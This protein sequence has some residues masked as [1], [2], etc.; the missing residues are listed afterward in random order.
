MVAKAIRDTKITLLRSAPDLRRRT[1]LSFL[2]KAFGPS[3][4]VVR[5]LFLFLALSV[6]AGP[7]VAMAGPL[8]ASDGS[9]RLFTIDPTTGEQTLVGNTG[10]FVLNF[11]TFSPG[12]LLYA[13]EGSFGLYTINLAT[14]VPTLVSTL[15]PFDISSLAFAPDGTFYG[16]D[17]VNFFKIDPAT[18]EETLIK[19]TV[20]TE[21]VAIT[22]L[23][24]APDGSLYGTGHNVNTNLFYRMDPLTG[25]LTIISTS[26]DV[27][28]LSFSSSGLLYG[29]GNCS[30]GTECDFFNID[31]ATGEYTLIGTS[32]PSEIG[33]LA[34]APDGPAGT[35]VPEPETYAVLF[36]GLVPLILAKYFVKAA[37]K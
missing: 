10:S 31:L 17:A 3:D 5:C 16:S 6:M 13:S 14:A 29:A 27:I 4:G 34:F 21:G 32:G 2:F 9:S 37:M 22:N 24:F 20:D 36:A 19:N 26:T 7:S 15:G 30:N 1:D 35:P 33:A 11:M 23:A 28:G 25:D 12:G 8:Y 18:G